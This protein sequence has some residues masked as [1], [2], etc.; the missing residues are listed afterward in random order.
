[1]Q[2]ITA[3]APIF[4]LILLGHALQRGWPA[5]Q[6]FW[7]GAERLTY[8]LFFPCLLFSN[9]LRVDWAGTDLSG[10]VLAS[11]L[12]VAVMGGWLFLLRPALPVAGPAMGS[13]LQGAIRPNTYIA[14]GMASALYGV[15]GEALIAVM[16]AAVVPLVNLLSVLGFRHWC[17]SG[18]SHSLWREVLANPLIG[19]CLLGL[20]FNLM[21]WPLPGVMA[22]T[23]EILAQP[24][25]PLGLLT[26]GA[27]LG[28]DRSLALLP[29]LLTSIGFKQIV[30]PLLAYGLGLALGLSGMSLALVVI[31]AAMPA[32][33][34]SY[35]LA[36]RL[37]GDAGF[38]ARIITGQTLA[39]FA[40]LPLLAWRMT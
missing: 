30:L 4:L 27:A 21:Q 32:S 13:L 18:E 12:V 20:V 24:A 37:G 8:F 15:A 6:D 22:A 25:L 28:R 40:L 34:S 2:H 10:V 29:W 23:L 39:S 19:A 31:Y 16:I 17:R 38:M 26:V 3:I 14:M 9:A 5:L 11:L 7:L 33:P 36:G 35:I 1:M